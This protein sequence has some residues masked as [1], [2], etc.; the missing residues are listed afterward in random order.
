MN[1]YHSGLM[2]QLLCVLRLEVIIFQIAYH[3]S[4]QDNRSCRTFYICYFYNRRVE[5]RTLCDTK[6]RMLRMMCARPEVDKSSMVI[7]NLFLI[8]L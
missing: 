3:N 8:H 5:D 4:S 7:M 6:K 1:N 2:L